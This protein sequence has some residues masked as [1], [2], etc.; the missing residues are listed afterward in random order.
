MNLFKKEYDKETKALGFKSLK[1]VVKTSTHQTGGT[2][3][4]RDIPRN[5]SAPGKR[6]SKL[7]KI[8]YEYRKNRSD[9]PGEAI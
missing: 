4:S 1:K 6:R 5:A 8:Y 9:L 3:K 2:T 7:G